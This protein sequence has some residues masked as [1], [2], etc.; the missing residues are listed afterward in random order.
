MN[1]IASTFGEDKHAVIQVK[2]RIKFQVSDKLT[3][4]LKVNVRH[5]HH[6]SIK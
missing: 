2:L 5:G 6:L 3:S 4:V 1:R